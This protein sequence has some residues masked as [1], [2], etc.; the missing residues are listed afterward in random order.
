MAMSQRSESRATDLIEHL[1][2]VCQDGADGYRRAAEDVPKGPVKDFL[3]SASA[4]R[5]E[6][7]SVITNALVA[8]GRKPSHHG[9]VAAAAHRRWLD[10][11][12]AVG[13]G[14]PAGVLEEGR[15]G[16]QQSL[17][18][19]VAAL[20][21]QLPEDVQRVVRDV[22]QRLLGATAALEEFAD[23]FAAGTLDSVTHRVS[24]IMNP[25]LLYIREGDR[26]ALAKTKI[27]EFGVTAVPVLDDEHRPVA[28]VS[29]RDLIAEGEPTATSPARV[30]AGSATLREG[31]RVL[32]EADVHHLV[33]V[34]DRGVAIG[35]VSSIDF[36]RAFVGSAPRHPAPFAAY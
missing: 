8:L 24:D 12:A 25:K 7:A 6:L 2:V 11:V 14:S 28:M 34:D 30:V 15:R 1:L 27:L 36:A 5:E 10:A 22:F 21:G 9:S 17:G 3:A 31:A 4:K 26:L 13:R 19:F 35:I 20:G 18:A 29:L 23:A 32:A 16:E 33:V